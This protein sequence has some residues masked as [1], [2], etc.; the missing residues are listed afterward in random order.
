MRKGVSPLPGDEGGSSGNPTRVFGVPLEEVTRAHTI[1]GHQVPALVKHIVDYI[2]EHGDL[3]V[4]GVFL[5]NGNAERVDWLR[6]R[7]DSGEEVQL[8]RE[9]DLA[10]AVSL[11]RLFLQ[12]LP[13]PVIPTAVQTHILQ[14]H[15]D[16]SSEEEQCRKLKYL[17]QQLPQV[18]YGLL[19]FLC[20]FLSSV[21]SL[22]SESWN[23]G[24][25][26]AVFGPDIFHLST[27]AEDL[28][29]Q[30]SVSRVL[31]ELL[32]N[33]EG[34]FDSDE[35]DVSTTNDYSSI[36][37]QITELLDDDKCEAECEDLPQDGDE[38]SSDSPQPHNPQVDASSRIIQQTIRA[39]VE[40]HLLELK[41]SID[42][43]LG[44]FTK[45]RISA[46]EACGRHGDEEQQTETEDLL[47]DGD[48]ETPA[49][50]SLRDEEDSEAT[51]EESLGMDLDQN[52]INTARQDNQTC[53]NMEET[54]NGCCDL[55]P[56]QCDQ[57]A[58]TSNKPNQN[59]LSPCQPH[60]GSS[61]HLQLFPD[62]QWEAPPPPHVHL[63]SID[64]SCMHLQKEGQDPVPAFK[65]WHGESESGEAQL[66][67]LA[68]RMVPLPP[69]LLAE[70]GEEESTGQDLSP[71]SARSHPHVLARR[72]LD[73][74]AHST[75][76]FLQQDPDSISPTKTHSKPRRASFGSKEAM[77]G[78]SVTHQ[79]TKKLQHL[80]KKIKQ[81]EEHFEKERNYKPSHGDKAA[82]PK[83]LKWMTDLTKIRR[84][85]KGRQHHLFPRSSLRH[86]A[87]LHSHRRQPP[88]PSSPLH[89]L[90]PLCHSGPTPSPRALGLK[91]KQ[92]AESELGPQTRPRSNT[93]PKSFGS[94]LDQA[95]HTSSIIV[96]ESPRPTREETME[97]I[98][99]SVRGKRED[100]CWPED[101]KKMTK[102]Q[103]SCEKTVL[104]KNLL[105]YEGIH[106]RPVTRE[107][108]LVMKPLYE[109]YRLVKQM[110]TRVSITP[111]TVS[112]SSKRRSQTLQ[113][114]IEGE[115]AHFWEEIRD[116]EEEEQK[117]GGATEE[118]QRE[119]EREEE[120]EE[121][122]EED[123]ESSGGETPSPDV[124]MLTHPMS[125]S[126]QSLSRSEP[127]RSKLEEGSGKLAMDL[128][129][130]SSNA[131]SMPELLEQ[132]WKTRAEKKQMRKT[133]REFEEDFYQQNGRNVQ[134]ED[135]LPMLD[136]YREYKRIKAKLRLLEVLISKQ[137]SSKSI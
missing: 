46:T 123:G 74:G 113:P 48:G 24:A 135:R 76:R 28:R 22:Q 119:E 26:A 94:T 73:F 134:K 27:D 15:Q 131:S 50:Q 35:E 80:K 81:F 129:L 53:N 67:P 56:C 115:T 68:G 23:V 109:R 6:Q 83:V 72:F 136:E 82:N 12:E 20:R 21:A 54:D 86:Q 70:E 92:R 99:R 84:Q 7:Y 8:Q 36:N 43:D 45:Q 51:P 98:Q 121:D 58:N 133:I 13:E 40:H 89:T 16:Y 101:I 66:S 122:E 125:Q 130:S 57:N 44:G 3:D 77:K 108:R 97:L 42:Q 62:D 60:T 124:I 100:D 59:H 34:L 90:T 96:E 18:N 127:I 87:L 49:E 25:L 31:A 111:I 4:E 114:I 65:S 78:D 118:E 120:E 112:P 116:E 132:L 52:N 1:G 11:L 2:E 85:I 104:Q 102:E 5:V 38:S 105:H 30:E 29:E 107:E 17:L 41:T 106:G 126:D 79:L 71:S 39:A 91:A 64:F 37:E 137:D 69:L 9:A 117:A 110:L 128:R 75:Q 33:Q 10:A 14:L 103:L 19:R 55:D 61:P 95:P 32:D 93:L 88:P 63:P 47:C